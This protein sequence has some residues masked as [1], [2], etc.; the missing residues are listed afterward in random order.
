VERLDVLDENAVR[1]GKV[2]ERVRVHELG[3]WHHSA[4]VW[5]FGDD[6][7]LLQKR[8]ANKDTNGGLWYGA[9]AGHI[10]A[11]QTPENCAQRETL[12][13]LGIALLRRDLVKLGMWQVVESIPAKGWTNREFY[14]VYLYYC[15]D[16]PHSSLQESEVDAV[17]FVSL[18]RFAKEIHDEKKRSTFVNRP[19][20]YEWVLKGIKEHLQKRK[21]NAQ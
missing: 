19:G 8:A 7:V 10:L 17:R 3:L 14:H 5:L 9:A 4:H 12:E 1:T 20:Y 11:G 21:M 2:E 13:E 16:R 18:Q 6:W 15:F